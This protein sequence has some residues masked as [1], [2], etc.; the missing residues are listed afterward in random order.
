MESNKE[1]NRE[2]IRS[3][4]IKYKEKITHVIPSFPLIYMSSMQS[5]F[6]SLE[7]S[8]EKYDNIL[9]KQFKILHR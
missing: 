9:N 7:K 3:I 5:S 1:G 6:P 2:S 4:I 8:K